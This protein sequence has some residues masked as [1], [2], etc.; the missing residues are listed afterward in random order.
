MF[1][2]DNSK[3][4]ILSAVIVSKFAKGS[5]KISISVSLR[6]ARAR[7]IRFFSP[8]T[9]DD[10][11]VGIKGYTFNGNNFYNEAID[12]GASVCILDND[13]IIDQKY[14]DNKKRGLFLF[15]VWYIIFV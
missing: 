14:I 2:I 13:T 12:N 11:Y 9:I 5:S 1:S 7:L 10:V 6:S 8:L 3:S 4:S 15:F